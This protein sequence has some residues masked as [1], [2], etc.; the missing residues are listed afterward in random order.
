M[1]KEGFIS[2]ETEDG[3]T[4]D[5]VPLSRRSFLKLGAGL[6]LAA[7]GVGCAP[8]G[9]I[10]KESQHTEEGVISDKRHELGIPVRG[11]PSVPAYFLYFQFSTHSERAQVSMNIFN[12]FQKGEAVVVTYDE[13]TTVDRVM[14]TVRLRDI[15]RKI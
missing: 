10:S 2:E 13:P 9:E 4:P 8:E 11:V 5:S 3:A 1:S 7:V 15:Q 12:E 14:M 6:G